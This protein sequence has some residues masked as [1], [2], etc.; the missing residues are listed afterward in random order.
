M[1][2]LGVLVQLAYFRYW[3]PNV[4]Q[5]RWR[6]IDECEPPLTTWLQPEKWSEFRGKVEKVN[7]VYNDRIKQQKLVQR[8]HERKNQHYASLMAAN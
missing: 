3:H 8:V 2:P 5:R 4:A 1:F 7:K 6:H